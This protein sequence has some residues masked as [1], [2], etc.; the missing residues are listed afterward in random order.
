MFAEG[1]GARPSLIDLR[2]LKERITAHLKG[3]GHINSATQHFG[4]IDTGNPEDGDH[5]IR[6]EVQLPHKLIDDAH[7]YPQEVEEKLEQ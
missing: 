6:P 3:K 5:I 7:V 2:K 1:G 4:P